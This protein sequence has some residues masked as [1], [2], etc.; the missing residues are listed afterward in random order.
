MAKHEIIE[1][2]G[3]RELL[4]PGLVA[5]ALA[6]ND[7]VKY[8][9]ALLQ[10]ARAAADGASPAGSLREE[11]LAS[12]VLDP[13]LDRLV[14]ASTLEPDGRYRIPR[15]ESLALK[16]V[17]EVRT[18]ITPLEV[19]GV[20]AAGRLR[21][22]TEAI[23]RELR[24]EGDLARGED[25]DLLTAP[26]REVGDSLH[27]VVM[28]AHRELGALEARMATRSIDG[29]YVHDLESDEEEPVRAFMRGLHR[30]QRLRLDHPGLETVA[31]HARGS[32]MI[33][34]DIGETDA[35]VV[36]IRVAG[37]AITI[38][39]TDLH[40][41]RLLF[42]QSRLEGWP[43]A[44]EDTRSRT[45]ETID[46]GLYHLAS[47]RLDARD[48]ADVA[49]FLE[50]LGSQLV[51]IID[52]NRARKRLRRLV[53]RGPAVE[54]LRFAAEH[55]YGHIPFLRAGGDGLIY[56]A[57]EFAG[58]GV[59]RAGQSLQ[60]V[61]GADGAASYLQAVLRICSE[62]L[63]A[64]EP[65]SLVQDEVRA[66]LAG[67]LRSA[68]QEILTLALRH[69]E[70]SAEIAEAARDGVEQAIAGAQE[71]RRVTAARAQ[72]GEHAA[73]TI[74]SEARAAA[75]RSPDMQP[76]LELLEAADDVADCAEEAA[77]YASLLPAGEPAGGVRAHVRRIAALVLAAARE[78]LRAVELS[79]DL[80]R[81]APPADVD[82]FL[83]AAHRAIALE[84]DTDAAQ[85]DV[86]RALAADEGRHGPLLFV[87]VELTRSFEETADALMHSAHLLRRHALERVVGSESAG[88][89]PGADGP[90]RQA[91]A[92]IMREIVHMVDD[93]GQ[94]PP[95]AELIGAKAHSLARLA[96]A[97]LR[98]P[99]AAVLSTSLAR[100][101]RAGSLGDADL[102]GLLRGAV[103]A[104][105]TRTGLRFGSSRAPL[106]LSVRSGAPV[107]MPGMLETVLDVGMCDASVRG[108]IASTGN[109]GLAWDCY[110]RFVECYAAVVRGCPREAFEQLLQ[111]RLGATGGSSPRELGAAELQRLTRSYIELFERLT[112]EQ[113]P[114]SPIEQLRAAVLAVLESWDRPRAADYRR[115]H[116]IPDD[117]GTAVILQ[118]MVF[119][120]AGGLSGSGVAFTRDPA[121]GEAGLYM[122]FLLDAQGEDVVGGRQSVEGRAT[123]PVWRRRCW[124]RS[125]PSAPGSRRSSRTLRSSS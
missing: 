31:T 15:A 72:R 84:R 90:F 42:F 67:Y 1:A 69:A 30:T 79:S 111:E 119:G 60:D 93:H 5:D 112:G 68:R 92:P 20:P 51:F 28:Q 11:R 64:G 123:S 12:G 59:V 121:G 6:S 70:L 106:V 99:E 47:G 115:L 35:H 16:A 94:R 73:D 85:R 65:V 2:L 49:R 13:E 18:M 89:P 76:L 97:G 44:W 10:S 61:L 4:L 96:R 39:Y 62:G 17:T 3:E 36:V 34:N 82:A 74:L 110:R 103:A 14:N 98:V 23:A 113:L 124:L 108:L 21:E 56:D 9:L 81:G 55:E 54:L 114:Q 26:P 105:E 57:L 83:E 37:L 58:A 120:N 86:H 22:R 43:V 38:T 63:L 88:V 8:L 52:W 33:Q 7:R 29:A 40:L 101:H 48:P 102:D 78:Y 41:Q 46:G 87:V 80:R 71:R 109:P 53:G 19:A 77:F 66:E 95:G 27:V 45:D 50:Q 91:P 125:K 107:S 118:R 25:L 32:L 104:L 116:E 24:F 75:A 117:L 122:D 100:A